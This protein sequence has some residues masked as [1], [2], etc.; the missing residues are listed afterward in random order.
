MDFG[1]TGKRALVTGASRGI[2]RAIALCLAKEGVKVAVCA[3]TAPELKQLV[4]D[5]GGIEQGHYDVTA[6]LTEEHIPRKVVSE[7]QKNFGQIDIVVNNVGSTLELRDPFCPL[8]DW[9][10]VYRINLEVAIELNNAVLPYMREKQ[11]GRIVN[12]GSTASMENNG[13]INYCTMK[14]ALMAYSRSLGRVLAQD[15]VVVSC[16]IPGAIYTDGGAW[17]QAMKERPEHVRKYLVDRCPLGKFGEPEDIGYMAVY[18]S[19]ALAKFCQG[20]VVPVDGG[21]SRHYFGQV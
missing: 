19:S 11:W 5:M 21:Q 2:G 17:E 20:A 18:L 10:K 1:I 9:R 14:A 12:I 16:I 3:R 15:G 8:E 13:P 6:D 7:L 4:K